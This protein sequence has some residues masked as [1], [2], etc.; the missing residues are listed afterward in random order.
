MRAYLDD[1]Q[2]E[3][4]TESDCGVMECVQGGCRQAKATRRLTGVSPAYVAVNRCTHDERLRI[5]DVMVSG[6]WWGG[7]GR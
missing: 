3:Y 5:W 7:E 1:S 6:E 2:N 4:Q